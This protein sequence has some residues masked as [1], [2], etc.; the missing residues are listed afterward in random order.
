MCGFLYATGL[1]GSMAGL[2][3]VYMIHL[4]YHLQYALSMS[5]ETETCVSTFSALK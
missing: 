4:T 5:V 1:D 2:S 3:L